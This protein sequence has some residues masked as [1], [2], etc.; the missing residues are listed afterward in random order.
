MKGTINTVCVSGDFGLIGT[1]V[2]QSGTDGLTAGLRIHEETE[3]GDND[4]I[5]MPGGQTVTIDG[6]K[7]TDA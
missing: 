7:C 2:L 4:T 5:K 6:K 3:R 1:I